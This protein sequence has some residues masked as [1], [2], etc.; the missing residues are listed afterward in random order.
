MRL[1]NIRT[2]TM[3]EFAANDI[4]DY[5]ILSHTWGDDEV[6]LQNL[7]SMKTSKLE[8]RKGYQKIKACCQLAQ[9]EP[10]I[11]YCWIDT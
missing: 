11:E 8:A 5:V 10:N 3:K 1:L 7:R 6:T 2:L 9:K 4:P